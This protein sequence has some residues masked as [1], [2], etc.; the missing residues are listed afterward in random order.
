MSPV[1]KISIIVPAYNSAE[2][3]HKIIDSVRAQTFDAWECIII[4]DGSSDNTE[5]VIRNLI[6]DD[7]R[8]TL[9]SKKNGGVGS[10]RNTGIEMAG[11]KYIAFYDADDV[12]PENALE[13]LYTA[14]VKCDADLVI[15]NMMYSNL[16]EEHTTKALTELS[17]KKII[18][19]FDELLSNSSSVCNKLFR[20]SVITDN[21]LAFTKLRRYEDFLFCLQF[22]GKCTVIAGCEDIVYTYDRRPYWEEASAMMHNDISMVGDMM[23]SLER[24]VETVRSNYEERRKAMAGSREIELKELDNNYERLLSR[25]YCRFVRT[26]FIDEI[27][28]YAWTADDEVIDRIL[29][30]IPQYRDHIFPEDWETEVVQGCRDL[31]IGK[32]GPEDVREYRDKPNL[33]FAVSGP[34]NPEQLNLTVKGIYNQNYP[35]FEVIMRSDLFDKLDDEWKQMLNLRTIS[36]DRDGFRKA[37]FE[38]CRGKYI[39]FIEREVLLSRNL[40]RRMFNYMERWQDH[41][42]TSLPVLTYR[43]GVYKKLRSNSVAFIPEYAQQK[44]RTPYNQLDYIWDNKVFSVAKLKA[45]RDP[46]GAKEWD[47][48]DRFYSNSKYRKAVDISVLVDM[49]DDDILRRVRNSGV[50]RSWEQRLRKEEEFLQELEDRSKRQIT[51][52]EKHK[53]SRSRR[54]GWIFMFM[55]IKVIY[56]VIYT[57]CRL[58]PVDRKKVIFVENSHLELTNS[59]S[60]MLKAI[61]EKGG[62]KILKM[63]LGRNK[64]RR[65]EQLR[66][67]ASFI[68]EF[69]TAKYVFT[70]DYLKVIGGFTKR[71]ET[72]LVQLWHGCGA[73]KKFGFSTADLMFGGTR[74][75]KDKYP[76][77]RNE[78]LITVSSPEVIWAYEEAMGHKGDGSVQATGI[79][80]TDV[81]FD[82]AFIRGAKERVLKSVPEAA[83]KKII[84][85]APTF[86]GRVRNASAPDRLDVQEM[87]EALGEEYFL[88]IKHHPFAKARPLIPGECR[89]FAKDVTGSISIDDLICCADICISD[90]SSLIFEYALFGRPMIFFA[91]DLDEYNDWRGFYYNYDEL[92]PGPVVSTTEEIVKYIENIGSEFDE[93][94]V[95]DFRNKYMSACDGHATERILERIGLS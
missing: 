8:F 90:Y 6:G 31:P 32:N 40:G 95:T 84:M 63:P 22:E 49:T 91:Y 54:L 20:K 41:L 73:F 77:Y 13:S 64:V 43:N 4:N 59:V 42:F 29:T 28:R 47:T 1:P 30:L 48:L 94:A 52:A 93:D 86:R 34:D 50:R 53:K 37:A 45:M 87:K 76:D 71:K 65:R 44:L 24:C 66:R 78:D 62:Y 79:S 16:G 83:G 88:L 67:E 7:A 36:C 74:E 18:H 2:H 14:A 26:N 55:T 38:S 12:V 5:E 56:P 11:G 69:A 19:P 25:L 75:E 10:A 46:F 39:W 85:Y 68:R 35:F 9:H 15:G 92:T 80:R 70:S 82:D 3:I 17:A 81:F 60:V 27:Y 72:T 51:A 61:E 23:E 21:G 89:D 58:R 57:F 33:T